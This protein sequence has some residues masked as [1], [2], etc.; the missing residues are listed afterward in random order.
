MALQY[1]LSSR[2]KKKI[3]D[4]GD[5]FVRERTTGEKSIWKCDQV[6]TTMCWARVHTNQ[7]EITR[8]IE[9]HNHAGNDARVKATKII[10]AAKE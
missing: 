2:K 4:N 9:E 7:D 8:R 6:Y 5:L 1:E 10:N 3:I